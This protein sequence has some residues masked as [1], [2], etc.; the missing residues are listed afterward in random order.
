M[1]ENAWIDLLRELMPPLYRSV[2]RRVGARRALAED[3]VQETWLRAVEAWRRDGLP[4]DPG[5]WLRTVAANL[6]R[7]Y[8]RRADPH[9]GVELEA[10]AADGSA[11]AES[12]AR[13]VEARRAEALQRGF[14]RLRMEQAALLSER[15]LEGRS[16]TD[17]ATR[18]GLTE[19]AV[20]GRLR[21]AR[22]ALA[23]HVDARLLDESH[24][25]DG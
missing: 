20:E 24:L 25:Q 6:L 3:V 21:R 11:G 16:L 12:E 10:W 4:D 1:D 5:A 7:N 9:T 22:A 13:E 15:H 17:I 8:Y 19:R 18:R 2:S 14:A 23:R